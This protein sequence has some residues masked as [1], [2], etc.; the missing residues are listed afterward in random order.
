[1]IYVI[2]Y[3]VIVIVSVGVVMIS[4]MCDDVVMHVDVVCV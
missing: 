2:D 3:D 4:L 1:M